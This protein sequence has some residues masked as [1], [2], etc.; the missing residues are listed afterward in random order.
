MPHLSKES[1][2]ILTA[3]VGVLFF[4]AFFVGVSAL[5][6]NPFADLSPE[7][8]TT[9]A[10]YVSFLSDEQILNSYH[11][12]RARL[13]S[14]DQLV[15]VGFSSKDILS[16]AR[17][18]DKGDALIAD[19]TPEQ[20]RATQNILDLFDE[21]IVVNQPGAGHETIRSGFFWDESPP[22][23]E[24]SGNTPSGS[25]RQGQKTCTQGGS[26]ACVHTCGQNGRYES[27]TG[28]VCENGCNMNGNGCATA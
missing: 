7:E 14:A 26:T 8:A 21:P 27:T 24:Q 11:H 3:L 20:Y 10:P 16:V 25:C 19:L 17:G 9:I 2:I 28:V 23:C 1:V 15:L 6:F 4:S 13:S 22:W 12:L 18:T 5:P